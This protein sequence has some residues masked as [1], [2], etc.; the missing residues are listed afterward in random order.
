MKA[1]LFV[2]L[3]FIGYFQTWEANAG[4]FRGGE[5]KI[6][7]RIKKEFESPKVTE[8]LEIKGLE[9]NEPLHIITTKDP[10]GK[11]FN[12]FIFDNNNINVDDG[13]IQAKDSKVFLGEILLL[14]TTPF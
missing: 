12:N 6:F 7:K 1:L 11:V 13:A 8:G 5:L 2:I 3:F 14:Y 10:K 9:I 4:G